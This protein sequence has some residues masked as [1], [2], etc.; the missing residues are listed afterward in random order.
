M[1]RVLF[2]ADCLDVLNDADALPS[3]SVDLIYLDPPFNSNSTYNLPFKGRDRSLKPVEAFEDTWR[4]G[5]GDDERLS[6]LEKNPRTR[7]LATIVRFAAEVE[8]GRKR[9]NSLAAYLL[10][11]AQR[12]YAMKRV[13]KETGS[14]YLH[15][16]PTASH[17]L[18]LLM[19]GI[20]GRK[21]FRNEIV[22][23]RTSS[24]NDAKRLGNTHDLLLCS[25]KSNRYTS[26]MIYLPY[27]RQVH[28]ERFPLPRR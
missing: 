24:H 16:D 1:N 14:L 17:Y 7:H 12:L 26:N 25:G 18:K 28:Q 23:K 3:Q 27:D 20:F 10:N 4:W 15:C 22:W 5:A 11:M 6:A 8:G 19:D 13:L 21:N 2:A 9:K